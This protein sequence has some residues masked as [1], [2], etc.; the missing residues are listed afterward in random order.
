MQYSV[1]ND[2]KTKNIAELHEFTSANEEKIIIATQK[3]K[4]CLIPVLQDIQKDMNKIISSYKSNLMSFEE[5]YEEIT[6][7][8]V[9]KELYI[10]V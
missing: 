7:L 6:S 1:Q 10:I 9:F 2:P 8:H 5:A 3:N 4:C